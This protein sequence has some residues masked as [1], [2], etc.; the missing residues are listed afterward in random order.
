LDS[1]TYR[2]DTPTVPCRDAV[3]T[4]EAS[5]VP[6]IVPEIQRAGKVVNT[7]IMADPD[8]SIRRV[9]EQASALLGDE[10]GRSG[11]QSSLMNLV[12]LAMDMEDRLIRHV[13]G[14]VR[15][16]LDVESAGPMVIGAMS[17]DLIRRRHQ[18]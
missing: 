8:A 13:L 14:C 7:I 11:A 5:A 4:S 2:V 16:G 12:F 10:Y 3:K 9:F 15:G 17:A 1:F 6:S 18:L